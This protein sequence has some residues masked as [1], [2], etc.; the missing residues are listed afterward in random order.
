MVDDAGMEN[1]LAK[2]G[3]KDVSRKGHH[4]LRGDLGRDGRVDG[5]EGNVNWEERVVGWLGVE[6]DG[7]EGSA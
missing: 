6:R 1:V 2:G 5:A 7:R 4:H 3:V